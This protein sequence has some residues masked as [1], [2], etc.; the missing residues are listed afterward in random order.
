M[1]S[2]LSLLV[3]CQVPL[4]LAHDGHG[5]SGAHW[6]ATDGLGFMVLAAIVGLALWATRRK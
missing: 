3:A 2:L 5:M 6:H 4:A 1:K